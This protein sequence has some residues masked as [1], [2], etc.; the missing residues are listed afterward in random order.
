MTDQPNNELLGSMGIYTSNKGWIRIR[1]FRD[2]DPVEKKPGFGSGSGLSQEVGSGSGSAEY[3][4][5]SATL[6]LKQTAM[7]FGMV[8]LFCVCI[9]HI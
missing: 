6:H 1:F 9:I 4:T 5:G 8:L 3:Q 2:P 7:C